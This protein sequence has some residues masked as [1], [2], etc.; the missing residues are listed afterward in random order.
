MISWLPHLNASLN[1]LATF[2]LVLGYVQIKRGRE[3]E[4]RRTMLSCFGVSALFLISYLVYHAAAGS[5]KF[6][7][8]PGAPP[9]AVR[10]FYYGIL[11]SHIVLAAAV[12]VLAMLT[13][14]HGLKDNRGKHR[15]LAKWTFPIWLYVSI[16]GVVVYWMLYRMGY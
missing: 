6:P 15:K 16:T 10:Y 13:I 4:H 12:P 3:L 2:L 1:A 5:K 14:Y 9:D 8:G 11:A 7:T